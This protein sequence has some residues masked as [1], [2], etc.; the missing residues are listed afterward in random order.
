MSRDKNVEGEQMLTIAVGKMKWAYTRTSVVS[1]DR[2]L[3][4]VEAGAEGMMLEAGHE[5]EDMRR[6]AAYSE[7]TT[8]TVEHS[9]VECSSEMTVVLRAD[10]LTQAL[11]EAGR[12]Q[13]ASWKAVYVWRSSTTVPE[14]E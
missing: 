4:T 7:Y 12:I 13:T 8:S 3:K 6:E 5:A 9:E 1:K 11:A 14:Q 2:V 10:T